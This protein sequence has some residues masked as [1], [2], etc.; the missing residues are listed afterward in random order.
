MCN[1][2]RQKIVICD[3][4]IECG[5]YAPGYKPP[6]EAWELTY[7][8]QG[9]KWTTPAKLTRKYIQPTPVTV[10]KNEWQNPNGTWTNAKWECCKVL[11]VYDFPS[12]PKKYNLYLSLGRKQEIY[13]HMTWVAD[14]YARW[15]KNKYNCWRLGHYRQAQLTIRHYKKIGL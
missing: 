15:K 2:S 1:W 3:W 4:P 7:M 5:P 11:A 12:I 9:H 10:R 8:W 13:E 6:S 14:E